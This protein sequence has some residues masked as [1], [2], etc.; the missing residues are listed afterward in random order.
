MEYLHVAWD[1]SSADFPVDI[2]TELD[3]E[4]WE[5]RKVEVFPDGHLQYADDWECTGNTGLGEH[6][7]PAIEDMAGVDE[8]TPEVID[9]ATFERMW[10]AARKPSADS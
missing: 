8:L 9:Q 3:E 5:V 1:Q 7:T 6:P 4:R 10:E 2:Y